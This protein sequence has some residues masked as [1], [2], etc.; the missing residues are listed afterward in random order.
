MRGAL[1]PLLLAA[2]LGAGCSRS[3]EPQAS[4]KS[5]ADAVS[6]V[7]PKTVRPE[8]ES[9]ESVLQTTGK[10]QFNEDALVRI[11]APATGRV[12]DVFARPGDVVERGTRLLVLDSADLG[13]AKADYAKAMAD[14][15]RSEA[16]LRL[17][18]E[19]LEVKAIAQKEIREAENDARKA[20]AERERAASRLQT[21]GVSA[22]HLQDIAT[23][24][25][26]TTTVPVVAPRSGVV[27]ERNVTPGQVVA[28]GQSDTPV[29][30]F[31]I[32]DLSTVWVVADVY[33][34]DVPRLR[35]GQP[36][37]VTLRCCPRERYEGVV[38]YISDI[39][40]KD[41][42]TVK[43]RAVVPN[44]ARALKAEMFVNIA[45]NTG[46]ARVLTI[47]QSAVHREGD[48]TFVL[49]VKAADH[50]ERRAVRL[51]S[52]L[53]DRIE[54]LSGLGPDDRIVGTGSILLKGTTR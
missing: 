29:S 37:V 30:L 3:A 35:R 13:A 32:A 38:S 11:H 21:L 5:A 42:R 48:Q 26:A 39:V 18:R 31:V 23:R 2:A 6:E 19:L 10:V 8:L 43:V 47:P 22:D 24:A 20:V 51:G 9:H 45:I 53:G 44:H 15:E 1:G 7:A 16:A 17:A 4:P 52:E 12:L 54:V 36:M 41:T 34:P 14:V 49:L 25:D 28:F 40:D 27:V 46:T 50:R 33:E